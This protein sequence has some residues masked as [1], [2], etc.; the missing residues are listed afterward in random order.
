V[1]AISAIAAAIRSNPGLT[2][3]IK[4]PPRVGENTGSIAA[5]TDAIWVAM[6]EQNAFS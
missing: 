3:A 1:T 6:Q 2:K 5:A 4:I